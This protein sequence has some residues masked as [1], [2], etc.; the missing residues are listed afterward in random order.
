MSTNTETQKS[1]K[2]DIFEGKEMV[3]ILHGDVDVANQLVTDFNETMESVSELPLSLVMKSED[4]SKDITYDNY[5][6]TITLR[7]L[8]SKN[9]F[10]GTPFTRQICCLIERSLGSANC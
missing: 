9:L 2:H 3:Y 5:F 10:M 1:I 8:I 4:N 6:D 7:L